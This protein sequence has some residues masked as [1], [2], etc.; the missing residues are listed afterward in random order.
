M[1]LS[2]SDSPALRLGAGRPPPAAQWFWLKPRHIATSPWSSSWELSSPSSCSQCTCRSH[3]HRV[4]PSPLLQA[5]GWLALPERALAHS[6]PGSPCPLCLP[7]LPPSSLS[8][9]ELCSPHVVGPPP[10]SSLA[11]NPDTQ[12]VLGGGSC[13]RAISALA[14]PRCLGGQWQL[15]GHETTRQAV[16]PNTGHPGGQALPSPPG[17]TRCVG[18]PARPPWSA[19][20]TAHWPRAPSSQPVAQQPLEGPSHTTADHVVLPLCPRGARAPEAG[21]ACPGEPGRRVRASCATRRLSLQGDRH[22]RQRA[23]QCH[24]A[25]QAHSRKQAHQPGLS[26]GRGQGRQSQHR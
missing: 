9:P 6:A 17:L 10:T 25:N 4:L 15:Q 5:A 13:V 16:T 20:S 18:S 23:H 8:H 2:A 26:T 12:Q 7:Y 1:G 21:G 11:L 24:E 22:Q 14:Y 19:S 3:S